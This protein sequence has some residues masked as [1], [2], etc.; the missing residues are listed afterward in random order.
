MQDGCD[1]MAKS[2]YRRMQCAGDAWAI[3]IMRDNRSIE[4][5]D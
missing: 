5:S 4:W 3:K 1:I 2:Q